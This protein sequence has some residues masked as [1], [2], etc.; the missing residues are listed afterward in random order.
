MRARSPTS[1]NANNAT[2]SAVSGV[3]V[4]RAVSIAGHSLEVLTICAKILDGVEES[5]KRRI[6]AGLGPS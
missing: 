3:L 4:V 5:A 1:A 6:E 2:K